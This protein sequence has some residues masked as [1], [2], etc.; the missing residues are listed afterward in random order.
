M[1][2]QSPRRRGRPRLKPSATDAVPS[3]EILAV[4]ARLFTEVGYQKTSF[5]T[6]AEAVGIQRASLYHHYPNK[7]ALLLEIGRPWLMPLVQLIEQ[8]DREDEPRDLQLYRYL[9]IDVRHL[10]SAPYDLVRLYQLP[11]L[12]DSAGLDPLWN[13]IDAIHNAWVDWIRSAVQA[14]ALRRVDPQLTGS[15]LE[16]NYLG[17]ISSERPS[18]IADVGVTSDSFADLMLG[19]LVAEP[20][21]LD[22]LRKLALKRDGKNPILNEVLYHDPPAHTSQSA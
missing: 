12:H 15:L 10:R 20:G 6:I 3:D 8:F 22:D 19:G 16:A 21:R 1:T 9:R 2:D 13:I 14:G 18:L 11:D 7:D 17:L 5:T 4:A